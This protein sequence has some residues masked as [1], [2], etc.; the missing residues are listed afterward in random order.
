VIGAGSEGCR[1]LPDSVSRSKSAE[2]Q[3]RRGPSPQTVRSAAGQDCRTADARRPRFRAAFKNVA[4]CFAASI[5]IPTATAPPNRPALAAI[6][7]MNGIH[8]RGAAERGWPIRGPSPER[9]G[10]SAGRTGNTVG[11]RQPRFGS[12][13]LG[14]RRSS[15]TVGT[16]V[17]G[18]IGD[19][20]A[21]LTDGLALDTSSG[22]RGLLPEGLAPAAPP[23]T[24]LPDA[25]E[26]GFP[27]A[28]LPPATDAAVLSGR[29]GA[30]LRRL[31]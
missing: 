19:W 13:I 28:L 9:A 11:L 3:V 29:S 10:A 26:E 27:A 20:S 8:T 25:A 6:G 24:S 31:S 18:A 23:H 1:T 14:R 5:L 4:D 12:G 16:P 2:G 7:R 17:R 21:A 30:R 22:R 15:S